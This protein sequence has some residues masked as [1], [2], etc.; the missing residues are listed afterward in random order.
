MKEDAL[1][2]FYYN[3]KK[4]K[5]LCKQ[6]VLSQKVSYKVLSKPV[7]NV[8]NFDIKI[9]DQ[10]NLKDTTNVFYKDL[11]WQS[12]NNEIATVNNKG[13][14]F[15][16]SKGQV[17]ITCTNAY[18][19]LDVCQLNIFSKEDLS[20]KYLYPEEYHELVEG[21][22]RKREERLSLFQQT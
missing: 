11:T 6:V 18:G 17:N 8:H 21:I 14:V 20:F 16:H 2:I 15:A 3:N 5:A 10:F 4:I 7:L 13:Q 19:E 9:N 22:N 12:S 1:L